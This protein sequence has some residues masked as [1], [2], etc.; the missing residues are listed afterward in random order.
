M[1]RITLQF[2]DTQSLWAFAQTVKANYIR[3]NSTENKL[4]CNCSD[5]E[6]ERSQKKYKA[7]IETETGEGRS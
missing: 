5:S 6:I 3:V 2:P 7:E 1:K 4:T